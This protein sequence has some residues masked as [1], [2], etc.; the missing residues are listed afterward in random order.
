MSEWVART[1]VYTINKG[2]H[3]VV[4]IHAVEAY[5]GEWMYSC[6]RS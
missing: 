5:R 2:E 3:E 6:T 1:K 4:N